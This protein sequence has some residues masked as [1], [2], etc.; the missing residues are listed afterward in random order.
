MNMRTNEIRIFCIAAYISNVPSNAISCSHHP[1]N[2]PHKLIHPILSTH[3]C[4]SQTIQQYNVQMSLMMKQN[5][6]QL[7]GKDNTK[8]GLV[9]S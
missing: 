9:L 3:F 1:H 5:P 4:M 7:S 6:E 2:I 8:L